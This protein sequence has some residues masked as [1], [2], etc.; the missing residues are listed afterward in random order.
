[1]RTMYVP[2]SVIHVHSSYIIWT[3]SHSAQIV[4]KGEIIVD[5]IIRLRRPYSPYNKSKCG[6]ETYINAAFTGSQLGVAAN[7]HL[8]LV[9]V[10]E[11]LEVSF[12]S[13]IFS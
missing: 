9:V 7:P 8:E 5:Y 11:L 2:G 3:S 13:F 4:L 12:H 1:M 6:K 10:L